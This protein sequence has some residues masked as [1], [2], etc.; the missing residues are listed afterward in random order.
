MATKYTRKME[1]KTTSIGELS[2]GW[3]VDFVVSDLRN[4]NVKMCAGEIVYSICQNFFLLSRSVSFFLLFSTLDAI[5][6]L[7]FYRI[8]IWMFVFFIRLPPVYF[9]FLLLFFLS[10][11]KLRYFPTIIFVKKNVYYIELWD[12]RTNCSG[13]HVSNENQFQY[14]SP[15]KKKA[16]MSKS[17]W[18]INAK[19]SMRD[20]GG[21]YRWTSNIE[22]CVRAHKSV[23]MGFFGFDR[24]FAN[25]LHY[26]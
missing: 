11:F 20:N 9:F 18:P 2:F 14:R 1:Q 3:L 4:W 22:M 5:H 12:D 13:V 6:W 24:D 8:I 26:T 21:C 19:L 23:W 17:N 10:W 7:N 16:L 25:G 15:E